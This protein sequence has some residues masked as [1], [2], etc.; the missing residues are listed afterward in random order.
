MKRIETDDADILEY[1][2][3]TNWWILLTLPFSLI[4]LGLVVF[5]IGMGVYFFGDAING[6]G[7]FNPLL[8]IFAVLFGIIFL[9]KSVEILGALERWWFRVGVIVD[10]RRRVAS[11]CWGFLVPLSLFE[12]SLDAYDSLQT[13]QETRTYRSS[14]ETRYLLYL[15]GPNNH[16]VLIGRSGSSEEI[17]RMKADIL[18]FVAAGAGRPAAAGVL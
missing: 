12:Y 18:A 16:R 11:K 5:M 8:L 2:Q 17:S 4:G 13:M 3:P 14:V 7:E 6:H 1:R 9:A 15:V 10:R